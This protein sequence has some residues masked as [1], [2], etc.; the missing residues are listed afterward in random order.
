MSSEDRFN[1][2]YKKYNG[3]VWWYLHNKMRGS[4]ADKEDVS[5]KIWQ[6]VWEKIDKIEPGKEQNVKIDL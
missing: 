1:E 5:Q 4:Y 3:L 2:I 6:G